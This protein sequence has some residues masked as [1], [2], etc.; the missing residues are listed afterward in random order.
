LTYFGAD[1]GR[2]VELLEELYAQEPGYRDVA[3]RL[4]SALVAYGDAL[5]AQNDWCGA[6]ARFTTAANLEV[7]P[8]LIVKRDD[9]QNICDGGG[10]V[11]NVITPT[12]GLPMT[13]GPEGAPARTAG[14]TPSG[15]PAPAEAASAPAGAPRGRILYSARDVATGRYFSAVQAVGNNATPIILQEDATQPAMRVDGLRIVFR[16]LREDMRGLG[17]VDPGTGLL[18]RFTQF[19]EDALPSWNPQGNRLVFAS[20]REG[21]RR[22]RVYA[23]WAETNAEATNLGFGEAPAWHPSADLIAFRGCDMTGNACGLWQMNSAGGDQSPL[24]T[25]QADN[26]P[27]WAPTGRYIVFM[28]DGR[29]GNME[30]YRLDVTSGQVLRLTDSPSVDGLPAVSPDGRWVA[31]VSNRDGAWKI[32]GVPITGGTATVLLPINGELGDWLEHGIQWIN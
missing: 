6:A 17:A 23:T 21:D 27:V 16:N 5:A 28:S 31:F 19:A 1:W 8:G 30:I 4:Q 22:W 9:S 18:L 13:S 11:A 24:T 3:G 32:W 29:D 20:N 2:T 25:V 7:T 14:L 10:A 26:R 15:A 12:A